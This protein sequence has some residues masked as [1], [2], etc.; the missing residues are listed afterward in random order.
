MII[1]GP[2]PSRRLGRSLG[3]NNIP[4]KLCSYSCVYC[5]IGRT[6]KMEIERRAHYKPEEILSEVDK[7]IEK[8]KK[9]GEP[10]DFL[11]FVPDGEPTLDINLGQ[12]IERLKSFGV[13]IAVITNASLIRRPDV[14]EDLAK[15]DLVS[16]KVDSLRED[17]W[18]KI[19][20]P[21]RT[22]QLSAILSGILAFSKDYGGELATETMLI[23]DLNDTDTYLREIADFLKRLGPITA[24]LSIPVRPPSE[25]WVKPPDEKAVNQAYQIFSR[26][27]DR[28]E[29][30]TGYEGNAFA[31]TGNVEE[32][33][34]SITSVHPMREQA[35][36]E[37]LEKAGADWSSIK[38]LMNRDQ[39]K[40]VE[41]EGEKFYMKKFRME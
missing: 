26:K 2:V 4:P 18:R 27:I 22:L 25:K 16:L 1:F 38:D 15:A 21:H 3:I 17:V 10:I 5:Q 31:F 23:K 7:K 30:L 9:A 28:V 35:V 19:N 24:Y 36:R 40:E 37:F 33:L 14:R 39:I 20:R 32:D 29:Y 13:K 6:L 41:Y 34:L 8:A 12:E 11:S